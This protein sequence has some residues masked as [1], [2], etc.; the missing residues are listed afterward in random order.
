MSQD[1]LDLGATLDAHF[2][3]IVNAKA[4]SVRIFDGRNAS[5]DWKPIERELSPLLIFCRLH[6]GY[7]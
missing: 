6:C 4:A 5:Q 1:V 3:T 7:R 2:F